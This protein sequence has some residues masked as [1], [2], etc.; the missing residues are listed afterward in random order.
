[1]YEFHSVIFIYLFI[2]CLKTLSVAQ[3]IGLYSRT[4]G[5]LTIEQDV[6]RCT[7][8]FVQNTVLAF[9]KG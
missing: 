9:A 3:A 4:V 1:M 7:P 6:E 8:S 5:P 2:V